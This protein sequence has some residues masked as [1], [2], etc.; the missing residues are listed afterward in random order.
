MVVLVKP[1]QVHAES[2]CGGIDFTKWSA[3]LHDNYSVKPLN[4]WQHLIVHQHDQGAISSVKP[5]S[6]WQHL[7]IHRHGVVAVDRVI[8]SV[9]PSVRGCVGACVRLTLNFD[10]SNR[11]FTKLGRYT[12]ADMGIWNPEGRWPRSRS[13][14]SKS[15]SKVKKIPEFFFLLIFTNQVKIRRKKNSGNFWP[16]KKNT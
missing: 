2:I 8:S 6:R 11:N 13:S 5:F 7:I 9:R 15:R 10:S 12:K 4:R 14:R 1:S 16:L 3:V